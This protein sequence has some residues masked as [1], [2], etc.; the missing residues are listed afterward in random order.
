M[1]IISMAVVGFI[2]GAIA[3]AV[4]PG[5]DK[6]AWWQTILLGVAGSI[7]GGF[8]GGIFGG[9]GRGEFMGLQVA[10]WILSI[11]GAVIALLVWKRIK[12]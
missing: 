7:V 4:V 12:K 9:D 1:G 2:V 8:I 10:G 5:S 3:R 11:V 6:M